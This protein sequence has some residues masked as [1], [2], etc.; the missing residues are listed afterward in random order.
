VSATLKA[1]DKAERV[2]WSGMLEG[3]LSTA[4][5]DWLLSKRR[6]GGVLTGEV[7]VSANGSG[8]TLVDVLFK[9]GIGLDAAPSG[10]YLVRVKGT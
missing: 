9:V 1:H 10:G 6:L 8:G 3:E 4:K 5:V 2:I 7:S